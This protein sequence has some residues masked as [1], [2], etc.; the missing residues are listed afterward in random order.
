MVMSARGATIPAF[1]LP[2]ILARRM[3][4]VLVV[5]PSWVG[6]AP[7]SQSPLTRLKQQDP[8]HASTSSRPAKAA[9]LPPHAGVGEVLESLFAHGELAFGK[10]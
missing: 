8:G 5:A 2:L 3:T 9:D 10:R 7:L 6:D 1:R 4:S